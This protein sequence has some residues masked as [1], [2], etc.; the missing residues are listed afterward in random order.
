MKIRP[1]DLDD[2]E[3][4]GRRDA[5]AGLDRRNVQGLCPT[6]QAEDYYDAGY[7][8]VTAEIERGW[9]EI[10]TRSA[11]RRGPCTV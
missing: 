11:L 8:E 3:A 2:F 5:R 6:G 7:Y 9:D 10:W 4:L 1:R